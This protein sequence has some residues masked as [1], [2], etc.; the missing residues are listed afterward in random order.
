MCLFQE[1]AEMLSLLGFDIAPFGVD[2]IVVNGVPEGYSAEAGKVQTMIGDL[3]LI[4]AEDHNAL[5]EMIIANLA[6]RFAKL[7]SLSGDPV[8]NPVEAQRLIDSLFAC[9][10]AEYTHSGRRIVAMISTEDIEKK[11]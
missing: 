5:P 9:E 1:H 6:A 11:F 7:G 4:L 8:T 10:N 2:T 3:L